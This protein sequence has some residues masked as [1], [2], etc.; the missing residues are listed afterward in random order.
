MATEI[1]FENKNTAVIF[2]NLQIGD[3]FMLTAQVGKQKDAVYMKLP[4][5]YVNER[6][7]YLKNAVNLSTGTPI[8]VIGSNFVIPVDLSI[9]AYK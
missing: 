4:N 6:D 2:G 8:E 3:K 1:K 5:L 7:L 9:T